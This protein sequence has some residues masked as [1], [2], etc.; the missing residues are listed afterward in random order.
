MELPAICFSGA[1][2]VGKTALILRLLPL[3]KRDGLKVAIVKDCPH[4]FDIKGKDS[5]KFSSY[6]SQGVLL[7]SPKE[8][9]LL[10]PVKSKPLPLILE[11]YFSDFDL[12][13]LEGFSKEK[14]IKKI[15]VLRK[16][17]GEEIT[18]SGKELIGVIA[19]FPVKTE[20][21]F[22][23]FDDT[24][25]IYNFICQ[26]IKKERKETFLEI[27]GRPVYTNRFVEGILK[28]ILMGGLSSLKLENKDIRDIKIRL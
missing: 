15:N 10:S 20:K 24:E 2:E 17:I 16:G 25:G 11:H 28:N 4:G 3:F 9:M 12:I 19:D 23:L 7:L 1:S 6:G 26:E 22:F 13:L 14:E 27:N 5:W 21:P 18:I 8:T